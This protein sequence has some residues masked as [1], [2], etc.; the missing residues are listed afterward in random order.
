MVS[1]RC[2]AAAFTD[3]FRARAS[4]YPL[5]ASVTRRQAWASLFIVGLVGISA[6]DGRAFLGYSGGVVGERQNEMIYI[7][8]N[9]G[10]SPAGG[11]D[12][13]PRYRLARPDMRQR[14]SAYFG[15]PA[16]PFTR[17]FALASA[18]PALGPSQYSTVTI[19][20]HKKP[21]HAVV[22]SGFTRVNNHGFCFPYYETLGS[23]QW[24][25]RMRFDHRRADGH[26][27]TLPQKDY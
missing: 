8:T 26:H 18:V 13:T 6:R 22:C 7:S 9:S 17:Q 1:R 20:L 12:Y 4:R 19:A 24:N 21:V 27:A 2:C 3:P 14:D 16:E 5:R 15:G 25:P 11:S 10:S 23:K